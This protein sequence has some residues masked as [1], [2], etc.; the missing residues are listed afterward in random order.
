MDGKWR[1]IATYDYDT[2]PE[3]L[4]ASFIIPSEAAQENGSKPHW[5][6]ALGRCWSGAAT[7]K[8]TGVLGQR[9]SHWRPR[10]QP[11]EGEE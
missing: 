4:L 1:P 5:A 7:K 8:F 6:I 3:V 10:P 9:P 2:C 11:P